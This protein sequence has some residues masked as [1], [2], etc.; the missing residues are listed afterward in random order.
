MNPISAFLIA[1]ALLLP[2]QALSAPAP[3]V[4]RACMSDARRLCASV[5][6]DAAKRQACMQKNRAK[7]SSGCRK[8]VDNRLKKARASC[9]PKFAGSFEKMRRCVRSKFGG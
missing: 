6:G 1:V 4:R 8:V 7:W 5:I 3:E 9:R 2:A